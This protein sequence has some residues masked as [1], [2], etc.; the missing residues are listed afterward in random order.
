MS[1]EFQLQF[2]ANHLSSTVL[3]AAREN[4]HV[5]MYITYTLSHREGENRG[6]LSCNTS[7]NLL[8]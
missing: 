3:K 4:H 7:G 8:E 6:L 2:T 5:Y 1:Q